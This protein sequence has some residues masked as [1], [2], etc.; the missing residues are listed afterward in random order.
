ME[1]LVVV[2]APCDSIRQY[3]VTKSTFIQWTKQALSYKDRTKVHKGWT[4]IINAIKL[5]HAW[6][7]QLKKCICMGGVAGICIWLASK[8]SKW[9]YK[10]IHF[11]TL[12][13]NTLETT[14]YARPIISIN[15]FF[16][17]MTSVC[18][19]TKN[20][21]NDFFVTFLQCGE[22]PKFDR[23]CFCAFQ[24]LSKYSYYLSSTLPLTSFLQQEY[25]TVTILLSTI[26][27]LLLE[28]SL[29]HISEPT[30]PC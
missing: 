7:G 12:L 19:K 14:L 17:I 28:L 26:I 27:F 1:F 2:L 3:I 25:C 13:K 21:L 23:A 18:L 15:L 6:N 9:T 24:F 10:T 16:K 20:S 4:S 30:R 29:I 11:V 22:N 8:S 5:L